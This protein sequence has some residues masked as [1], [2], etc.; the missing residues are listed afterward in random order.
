MKTV[1]V[2]RHQDC[3][4]EIIEYMGKKNFQLAVISN[5]GLLEGHHR[6]TFTKKPKFKL[7]YGQQHDGKAIN[8]IY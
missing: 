4:K 2:S 1:F 8:N 6:L 3:Q 7:Q 5:D